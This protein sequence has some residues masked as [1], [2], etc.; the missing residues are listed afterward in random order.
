MS[1]AHITDHTRSRWTRINQSRSDKI[2]GGIS[3]QASSKTSNTA[4]SRLM[5]LLPS[6]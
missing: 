1:T 3:H 2:R 5:A 6:T 4:F